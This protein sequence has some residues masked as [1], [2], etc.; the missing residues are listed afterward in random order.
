[1]NWS[2]FWWIVV[3]GLLLGFKLAGVLLIA[4]LV[5]YWNRK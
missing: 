5:G 1:M 4:L 3:I 2:V